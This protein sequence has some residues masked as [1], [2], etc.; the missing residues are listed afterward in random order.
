MIDPNSLFLF[1]SHRLS[2]PRPADPGVTGTRPYGSVIQNRGGPPPLISTSPSLDAV[3]IQR[4][5][6]PKRLSGV[7]VLP[8]GAVPLFSPSASVGA[9]GVKRGTRLS[10]Q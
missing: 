1:I 9:E 2:Q 3:N 6:S 4:N 7:P 8:P 10:G 5:P